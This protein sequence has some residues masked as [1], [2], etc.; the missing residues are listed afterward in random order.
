MKTSGNKIDG[1][2]MKIRELLIKY[3]HLTVPELC[4]NL[5]CSEATMRNDLW[6]LEKQ[7]FLKRVYGGAMS[8]GNTPFNAGLQ[9][10]ESAFIEEKKAIARFVVKTMIVESQT[11]IMDTGTTSVE[12][13]K[14]IVE[15]PYPLTILTNSLQVAYIIS[16]NERHILHLAGGCYDHSVGSFHD[17]ETLK[18][19]ETVCADVFFVCP[20]SISVEVGLAVPDPNEAAV[21]RLMIK[22]SGKVVALADHS[23]LEK[24]GF[25]VICPSS[26][27]DCIVTDEGVK[28]ED[29]IKLKETGAKVHI[30]KL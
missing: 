27:V 1:R 19:I 13:A 23:K 16:Q 7:G 4:G 21:K 14:Q 26:D 30:A 22:K 18:F 28:N 29:L 25:R 3:E 11:I 17:N 12:L 6:D 20:S 8:N 5:N 24:R 2:H 15:L 9:I 10:R